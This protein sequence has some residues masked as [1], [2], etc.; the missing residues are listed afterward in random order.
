MAADRQDVDHVALGRSPVAEAF[1]VAGVFRDRPPFTVE[2]ATGS[3][4]VA[5]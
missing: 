2:G 4:H 5:A 3:G 1:A